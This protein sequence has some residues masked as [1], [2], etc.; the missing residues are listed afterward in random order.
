MRIVIAALFTAFAAGCQAAPPGAPA[1]SSPTVPPTPSATPSPTAETP[2]PAL[3][4]T[5]SPEE[6]PSQAP[7][8]ACNAANVPEPRLLVGIGNRDP[9]SYFLEIVGRDGACNWRLTRAGEDGSVGAVTVPAAARSTV[10]VLRSSDCTVLAQESAA[11]GT[12][13]LEIRGGAVQFQPAQGV[14]TLAL[15]TPPGPPCTPGG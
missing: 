1:T 9:A 15:G 5:A 13:T 4:P 12:Y 10:R 7:L 6:S 3:T 11:A 8:A 2:S 14:D